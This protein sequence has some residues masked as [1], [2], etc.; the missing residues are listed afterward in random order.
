[1][2]TTL[3]ITDETVS[4]QPTNTFV[5]DL[6]NERISVRELIRERVYEEVRQYNA[7][8]PATFHGLVQ[9]SEAEATLNGY[10]MRHRR[11]IDWE[12]QVAKA[13]EAFGRNGFFILVDDRQAES[14]DDM[15]QLTPTTTVSFVKLVPLVGG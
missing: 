14:L 8:L 3:T 4:G 9:P 5:L 15:I 2:S 6:L 1:M 13:L 11:P 12:K 10:Q 7:K